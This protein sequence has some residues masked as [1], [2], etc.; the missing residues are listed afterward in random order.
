MALMEFTDKMKCGVDEIDHQHGALIDIINALYDVGLG[1]TDTNEL[2][3][4][5]GS[6][7]AYFEEHLDYEEKLLAAEGYPDLARHIREHAALRKRIASYKGQMGAGRDRVVALD[8]LHYIKQWLSSHIMGSDKQACL[9][10]NG[11]GQG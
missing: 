6:L 2:G 1:R 8:L 4:I 11:K 3:E 7:T 9:F 10:L 5:F